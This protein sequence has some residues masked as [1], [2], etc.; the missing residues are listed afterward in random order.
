MKIVLINDEIVKFSYICPIRRC[1][2]IKEMEKN[3][4]AKEVERKWSQYWLENKTFK[5]SVDESRPSYTVLIPPPNVTGVLH[6]GHVLNNSLQDFFIRKARKQGY[7]VNWV[8]GIDHAAIAT[9]AKVVGYLR[10]KGI[11]KSDLTRE[12]FLDYCWEWKEKYGGIIIDQ[13][14]TIGAGCDW[15][16]VTFTLDDHYYKAVIR[17]FVDLY[18][19]GYIYKGKRI[20]NW[21]CEARTALSNEEV[22]YK[23]GGEPG[24]LF[25]L[26]YKYADGSGYL[27]V[28]TTRPETIFADMA[29]AVNPD[30]DRYKSLL[31]KE[32]L[33]P[34]INKPIKIIADSYVDKEFGTGCL[35]VTPAHDIND[36]EIGLRHN[37][38]VIDI[39]NDDGTVNEL[40]G[41]PEFIGKDRFKVR[42]EIKTKLEEVDCLEKIEDIINKV[43]RSERTN[44][45]VEPKLS[46]QW[47]VD[48]KNISKK[49]YEVVMNDEVQFF[50]A[51]HKNTFNHWMT[52]IR[53]WCISR[54][55][56][57]GHRIPA[58][59]D[60]DGNFYVAETAEEA[61]EQYESYL[62]A[63]NRPSSGGIEGGHLKQDEDVLDTWA[64][65][66]LWPLEVFNGFEHYNKETGKIDITKSK[67]LDYYLPTQIIVTGPDIMFLW[68]TRMIIANY[69][70]TDRKP[71]EKVFFTGI[72]RDKLGR[73]LS[74]QLGN[75]PDLY[76]LIDKY[77]MDGI[78]YGMMSISPAGNDILFDEKSLE[79]GRN[80]TNKI[81]NAFRLIKSWEVIEGENAEN[82]A[83]FVW[84]EALLQK[85]VNSFLDNID[86]LRISEAL[87][88]LYSFV[89]DDLCSWYLEMI[90][91]EFEKPI[92]SYTY[93][94]TMQF[95]ETVLSLLNPIMPFITEEMWGIIRERSLGDLC[96]DHQ[97][98]AKGAFNQEV[99]ANQNL[100]IELVVKVRE[101]RA[102]LKLKNREEIGLSIDKELLSKIEALVPK[103]KKMTWVNVINTDL[104]SGS[105]NSAVVS[106]K[107]IIVHSEK[108]L[109][110]SEVKSKLEEEIKYT[111]GF[112]KSIETKLSNEKF[113]SNAPEKVLDM[114]RKKLSDG[115]AK[116][117]QL[118][119]N[120]S[121]LSA[122]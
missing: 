53:D 65:S 84:F 115:Q 2:K 14:K 100:F 62:K 17:V 105:S 95:F 96:S 56:W 33:I 82:E 79:I 89:W 122:N 18:K 59:Y 87:K 34:L 70:Y 69:E 92:D 20:I 30:D 22:F 23:E 94:R 32:V 83:I 54:Q 4:N 46:L 67:D 25:H 47:Y 121:Q 80:F 86:N 101:L 37:L 68:I 119:Q 112:I 21:D 116:L 41:Y 97:L 74:K 66:W 71:F 29:V 63:N 15:D 107:K 90:K 102:N 50:P 109:D 35:K 16:R 55:L 6:F 114:E 8:P 85:N 57:W 72:V 120:L 42:K 110:S 26:K 76:E 91:P 99:I 13:L 9:E 78:R 38:E 28:A 1:D 117:K 73:K 64:S 39:L 75:S 44:S 48:M 61:Y 12:Q 103:I 45:V 93:E 98:P 60:A 24:Q 113:V 106:G 111:R 81:W 108:K 118:E 104:D 88:D 36:Y 49:A 51:Y 11:K 10:E 40:C 3:F 31:G 27:T 7:N 58:W 19:K 52:N 43:G 5:S 77:G